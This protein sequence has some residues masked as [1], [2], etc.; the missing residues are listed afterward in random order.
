[1]VSSLLVASTTDWFSLS[2]LWTCSQVLKGF[3][4]PTYQCWSVVALGPVCECLM[5]LPCR[6]WLLNH[7]FWQATLSCCW[8]RVLQVEF[9]QLMK[10]K[11]SSVLR[12]YTCVQVLL[13]SQVLI[14]RLSHPVTQYTEGASFPYNFL[15]VML[16]LSTTTW[17]TTEL[18][19]E[20]TRN[21]VV[22][23]Q[24]C[25]VAGWCSR[26][27]YNESSPSSTV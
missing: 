15:T 23:Y 8:R 18:W 13:L 24:P 19:W 25:F 4:S 20:C 12:V 1:M 17:V 5:K 26:T 11:V 14:L 6:N 9:G 16:L 7:G 2:Q 3:R 22:C 27:W 21:I 10:I